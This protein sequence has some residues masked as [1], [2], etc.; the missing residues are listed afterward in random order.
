MEVVIILQMGIFQVQFLPLHLLRSHNRTSCF[1]FIRLILSLWI[2]PFPLS[3]NDFFFRHAQW[4][5][6]ELLLRKGLNTYYRLKFALHA[7]GFYLEQV[8]VEDPRLCAVYIN[9]I[10]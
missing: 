6:N 7:N 2:L 9:P 3:T 10:H 4:Q 8:L 5:V 1:F